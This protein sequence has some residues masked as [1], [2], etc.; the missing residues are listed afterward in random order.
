VEI[1]LEDES[2]YSFYISANQLKMI[3]VVCKKSFNL[4]SFFIYYITGFMDELRIR[5]ISNI[6][7]YL[8]KMHIVI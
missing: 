4:I 2:I 7:K 1:K 5:S 6:S 3:H 8:S